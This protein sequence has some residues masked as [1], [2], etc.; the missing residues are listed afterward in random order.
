MLILNNIIFSVNTKS[1]VLSDNRRGDSVSGVRKI[2]FS[3]D[4][5]LTIR[6]HFP[7]ATINDFK[8]K[9]PS[10]LVLDGASPFRFEHKRTISTKAPPDPQM[11][12]KYGHRR[13]Q[14]CTTPGSQA[15]IHAMKNDLT[16]FPYNRSSSNIANTREY[17]AAPA[18][19]E[20]ALLERKESM[21]CSQNQSGDIV[22]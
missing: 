10:P 1:P 21:R 2:S 4:H 8:P 11:K 16:R 20:A 22:E 13:T 3:D 18:Y 7:L 12:I 17:F 19:N 14:S 9:I 5:R 6:S 15:N